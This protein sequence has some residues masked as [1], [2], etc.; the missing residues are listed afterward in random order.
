MKIKVAFAA[1]NYC[2]TAFTSGG[3]KLNFHFLTELKKKAVEIDIFAENSYNLIGFFKNVYPLSDLNEKRHEYDLVLSEKA[4]VPSDITYI[5]DHSNIYRFKYLVKNQIIYKSFYRKHY[6]KRMAKDKLIQESLMKTKRIIVSSEILK[7]DMVE[8]YNIPSE[9]IY[10]I[11]PPV[12]NI[13]ESSSFKEKSK[14]VVFGISAVGFERKGGFVLLKAIKKLKKLSSN[15]KVKI[16]HDKPNFVIKTLVYLY[17]IK[18]Y[19]SFIPVSNDI[20]GFYD[21]LDY[22]IAPSVIEPFGMVVTEAMARKVPAIV[23]TRC[24]A[25]E[26]INDEENGFVFDS[27]NNPVEKLT[28]VMLKAIN[29]NESAYV[30]MSQ[31]AY[32]SVRSMTLK[33]FS[34]KYIEMFDTLIYH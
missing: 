15:F 11:V 12:S 34:D 1:Q 28:S 4:I 32:D 33:E 14:E 21:L 23:G 22:L 30:Q 3:V 29:L 24:G 2:E 7:K 5:H 16:I 20:N 8:N 10:I 19:V 25:S 9:K 18:K 13:S 27:D 6:L 26:I 31:K 17:G